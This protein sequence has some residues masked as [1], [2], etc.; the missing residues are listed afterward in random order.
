MANPKAIMSISLTPTLKTYVR[1]RTRDAHFGTPSEYFR[2]LIRD[3][4]K[5]EEQERLEQELMKGFR[6]GKGKV[7]TQKAWS[8]LRRRVSA[9]K[10]YVN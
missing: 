7:M 10:H 4:F 2:A 6:S 5:R 1:Q 8:Q 3:D 9:K